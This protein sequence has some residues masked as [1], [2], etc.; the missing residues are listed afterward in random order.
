MKKDEGRTSQ[1]HLSVTPEER[2]KL[3]AAAAAEGLAVASYVRRAA[4][5]LAKRQ[6][7]AAA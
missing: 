4:I 2:E 6:E 7:T 5:L 3:A 1:L